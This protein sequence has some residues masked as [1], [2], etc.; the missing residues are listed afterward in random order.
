MQV[1]FMDKGSNY[2]VKD[3]KL[4]EQGKLNMEIAESRMQALMK[5]KL[6]FE[7]EKP[8]K[9]VKIGLALHVTKE[10]GVLV[11]LQ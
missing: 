4:A 7:K 2:E 1:V 6:R 3:I 11:M 8:L 9:G 10:T 5:V